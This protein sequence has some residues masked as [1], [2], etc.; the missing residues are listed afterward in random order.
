MGL[1]Q[2]QRGTVR[3]FGRPTAT[4]RGRFG[5]TPQHTQFDNQFP[6]TVLDIV[7]MGR[8]RPGFP[9][10]PFRRKDREFAMSAL[11]EVGCGSIHGRPF[12]DLSGG[13]RQRVLIARALTSQPE[14]LFLDE[15][16]ANLDPSIQDE[17]YALLRRL[18]KRMA[19]IIVSH[20]V[21]FVSKHVQ[22]VVCVNRHV[23]LHDTAE[24]KGSVLDELY[25]GIGVRAVD[26]KHTH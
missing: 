19:V 16:S 3:L 8:L 14:A 11:E 18:T 22:K 23:Y 17:F 25:G 20:D 10:G 21:G 6:V 9:L 5:Y 1:L 26:H 13:Q 4:V 2:P 7:L 15:P 24:L 12:S